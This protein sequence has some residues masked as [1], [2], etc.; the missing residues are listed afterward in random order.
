MTI[1]GSLEHQRAVDHMLKYFGAR[2]RAIFG[3]MA[4]QY[5]YGAG[6]FGKAH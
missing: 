3:D 1:A 6:L 2:Q 5:Q 4:H